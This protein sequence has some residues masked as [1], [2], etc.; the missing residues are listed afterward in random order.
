MAI[1]TTNNKIWKLDNKWV[2]K[3]DSVPPGPVVEEVTIG[4]QTWKTANLAVDDGGT[5]ITIVD[6]VTANGVNFGTQYYYTWE[7]AKRVAN[8]IEGWH[9][10]TQAEWDTLATAVGGASVAGIKLKSTSGWNDN[11]NGTDDFGFTVLPVGKVNAGALES[12]GNL[13]IF[14][15]PTQYDSNLGNYCYFSY[16]RTAK[17]K[18]NYSCGYKTD[19][20]S[21]R[22]IKDT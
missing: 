7:A 9:L 12:N 1:Y 11:T 3:P 4:T 20:C 2:N 18:I 10:P 5:G 22:L 16:Y 17:D 8:S 6:N 15:F 13:D 19:G 21:V 14:W